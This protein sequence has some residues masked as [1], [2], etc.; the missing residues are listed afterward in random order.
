MLSLSTRARDSGEG[1]GM[2]MNKT[3]ALPL[4]SVQSRRDRQGFCGAAG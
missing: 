4:M 2:D 1:M 3:Q